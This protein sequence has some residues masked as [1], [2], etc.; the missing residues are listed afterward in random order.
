MS[1]FSF[2]H[3][4]ETTGRY[5]DA[6]ERAG[7][8]RPFTGIRLVNTMW[9]DDTH[10][11][12]HTAAQDG[13]LFRRLAGEKRPLVIDRLC[14]GA[15][16]LAGY[17][18]DRGLMAEYAALLGPRFL[19]FQIHE[20][21]CNT[22]ND[23]QRFLTFSPEYRHRPV[24]R[25]VLDHPKFP[26]PLAFGALEYEWDWYAGR[27]F[28]DSLE[29]MW[30]ETDQLFQRKL[31]ETANH[32]VYCEGSCYGELA[33]TH[34]YRNGAGWCMF[35]VGP[36]AGPDI[37]FGTAALRG[38]ARAHGKP[39][40]VFYAPWGPK[41][42]TSMIPLEENSWCAPPAYF[43]TDPNW[44]PSPDHGPSSANQ[45]HHFFHAYLA[46]AN[47]L[48][49]EWGAECNL[50]SWDEAELSSYGRVTREFLDF[51]E[52]NPDCG[53]PHTPVALLLNAALCPP[54]D[55]KNLDATV[56]R[57]Y[58]ARPIDRAW[59]AVRA[60]IFAS[61]APA[62]EETAGAAPTRL[63]DVYDIVPHDAPPT[64]LGQYAACLTID[65]HTRAEAVIETILAHA[66]FA[67]DGDLPMQVNYRKTDGAW[68]LAVYNPYGVRRGDVH[69]TGSIL[70]PAQARHMRVVPNHFTV[71]AIRILHAH[72]TSSAATLAG[73]TLTF[74]LAPGG[75]VVA[76]CRQS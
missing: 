12:N 57:W 16:F 38:A 53:Q 26:R 3:S 18:Y 8:V 46:G 13:A 11:F 29:A 4:Y 1:H 25:A 56:R 48:Y 43:T 65:E 76:E 15:Q 47:C 44:L 31:A 64:L 9:G 51:V 36:W 21:A 35:E 54:T 30:R 34:F 10:R 72:G 41:G 59:A 6:I 63:P 68:I 71:K 17:T 70:D 20:T 33:W 74:N 49:E 58:P 14:G 62:P 42:C 52:A 67:K 19:G 37:Q 27:S 2:L 24:D 23:W 61:T 50:R 7:L 55:L 75:L 32:G 69:H 60:A 66:P 39:W 28:P 73:N 5:Y 45:R 22:D 40:G